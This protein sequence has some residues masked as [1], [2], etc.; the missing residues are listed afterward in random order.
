[1]AALSLGI[2]AHTANIVGEG[3]STS[4]LGVAR[5]IAECAQKVRVNHSAAVA[6]SDRISNFAAVVTTGLDGVHAQTWQDALQ[7]FTKTLYETRDALEALQ[8]RSYL[9]QLL[10]R[11]RDAEELQQLTQKVQDAFSVLTMSANI[12]V[13]KQLTAFNEQRAAAAP[14]VA[15]ALTLTTPASD[16]SSTNARIPPHPQRYFGRASETQK[17]VDILTT[18]AP[19][20]VAILG[21]PGMGKTSVA[22]AVL[23]DP[24]VVK[25]YNSQRFFIACDAAEGFSTLL[26]T[27]CVTFGITASNPSTA[28]KQ[29]AAKLASGS[30]LVLDNLESAWDSPRR[31]EAEETLG[32]LAGLEGLSLLVTMR[33]SER[34]YGPAWTTPHLAPLAPLDNEAALQLFVSI[35]DAGDDEPELPALVEALGNVPLAV[36]LMAYLAQYESIST[37]RARWDDIKT[38][39]LTRS[40]G[41]DRLTSVDVSI[42]LSISSSRITQVP[43][44]LESL[45]LLALL[46]QGVEDCDTAVWAPSSGAA[47]S[48]LLRT[49][50][51]YRTGTGRISVLAPIRE[52]VLSRHPPSET[53]AAPLYAHYFSIADAVSQDDALAAPDAVP[54][55]LAE[56]DNIYAVL[57]YAFDHLSDPSPAVQAAV[58]MVLLFCR[59][60]IGAFDLLPRTLSVAKRAGLDDAAADLLFRWAGLAEDSPRIS[61]N[62]EEL[63]KEAMTLYTKTGNVG[64]MVDAS[65]ILTHYLSMEEADKRCEEMR[66]LAESVGD[67]RRVAL[68]C[69]HLAVSLESAGRPR[70]ADAFAARQRAVDALRTLEGTPASQSALL[71]ILLYRVAPYHADAGDLKTAIAQWEEAIVR[72]EA[73]RRRAAVADACVMLGAILWYQGETKRA[74]ELLEKALVDYTGSGRTRG[75][76]WALR[77]LVVT[78]LDADDGSAAQIAV[79][80]YER[81]LEGVT[82]TPYERA[83]VIFAKGEIALWRGDIEDAWTALMVARSFKP[84]RCAEGDMVEFAGRVQEA[85][86]NIDDAAAQYTAAALVFYNDDAQPLIVVALVRLS[87]VLDDETAECLLAPVIPVLHRF[88]FRPMLAAALLHS[89]SIEDRRGRREVALRRARCALRLSKAVGHRRQ[90][91]TAETRLEQW[92]S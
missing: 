31:Q 89:A 7:N 35:S 79:E 62:S 18:P 39:M 13:Q 75:Q 1:M 12:E 92:T 45:G 30:L 68:C 60:G 24:D 8:R 87:Q 80:N 76:S 40:H 21:G 52:F 20:H 43:G 11:D 17:V 10:H 9:V 59:V 4:V 37:L 65:L 54:A 77:M 41:S 42:E 86:G 47:V 26:R 23:H 83:T 14:Q 15:E 82:L 71:G 36:T 66:A 56:V 2:A 22:L 84:I 72:M 85:T 63:A 46:P 28:Q 58:R 38:A 67:W 51:A 32:F 90:C 34:P 44:A 33:G 69:H 6:L 61:G 25:R 27:V 53:D 50:L 5:I 3:V 81:A 88:A 57:A 29:L 70:R 74:V 78:L 16:T 49:C 64:G 19:A 91:K 48:A 73:G 55:L